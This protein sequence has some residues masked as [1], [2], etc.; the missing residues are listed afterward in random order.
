ME[1]HLLHCSLVRIERVTALVFFFF[2]FFFAKRY[3]YALGGLLENLARN[4]NGFMPL[5]LV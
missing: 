3:Y 2:F 5:E 1:G 4:G